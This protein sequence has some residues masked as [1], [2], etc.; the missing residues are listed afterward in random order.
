MSGPCMCGDPYCGSCGSPGLAEHEAAEERALER[1]M[2]AHLGPGEYELAVT[3]GLAAVME[4]RKYAKAAVE[5]ERQNSSEYI[6]HLKEKAAE[7]EKCSHTRVEGGTMVYCELEEGHL[8]KHRG[9]KAVISGYVEWE[10][11]Q[12]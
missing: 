10:V 5:N 4:A 11:R 6:E 8:G 9:S 7:K 2:E 3:V 1:F 12:S